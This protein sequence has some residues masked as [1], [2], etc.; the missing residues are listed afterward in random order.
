MKTTF[1]F[2][3]LSTLIGCKSAMK[4]EQKSELKIVEKTPKTG[5]S[6]NSQWILER[7]DNVDFKT[8]TK[9]SYFTINEDLNSFSVNGGCNNIGGSLI[10]K[11]NFITFTKMMR[12]QMYCMETMKQEDIFVDNI[13]KTNNFKIVGGEL[14]LYKNQ[15]LLMTLESFRN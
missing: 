1:F 13:N 2:L 12:T 14:F 6:L 11:D 9:D 5:L 3:L 10:I 8:I 15:E 7:F 4:K